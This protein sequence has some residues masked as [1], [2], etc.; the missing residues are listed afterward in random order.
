MEELV[1]PRNRAQFAL[2]RKG[3]VVGCL[4]VTAPPI[5]TRPRL[6]KMGLAEAL[7]IDPP[8]FLVK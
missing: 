3:F 2:E 4:D 7:G 5:A 6:R 8:S 1:N